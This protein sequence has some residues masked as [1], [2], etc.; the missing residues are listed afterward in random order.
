MSQPHDH[1]R[2]RSMSRLLSEIGFRNVTF[3]AT[4]KWTDMDVEQ[5]I[6][7]GIL[8]TSLFPRMEERNDT[9]RE[10]YIKYAANAVSQIRRIRAAA[11]ANEPVIIMEDDLMA[12]GDIEVVRHNLCHAL[13]DIPATADMVYLEYCFE[14]CEKLRYNPRYPTLAK[15]TRP[16][17]AA[18]IFFTM[19]GARRVAALCWPVFDVIDRMYPALIRA[20]ALEAYLLTPQAFYQD[21]IFA[22]NMHRT[23]GFSSGRAHRRHHQPLSAGPTCTEVE[24]GVAHSETIL[25]L[26]RTDVRQVG[27]ALPHA[28]LVSML[29]ALEETDV[30]TIHERCE[31]GGLDVWDASEDAKTRHVWLKFAMPDAWTEKT[32]LAPGCRV[33]Y[34]EWRDPE[35]SDDEPPELGSWTTDS[36]CG[37]LLRFGPESNCLGS[38]HVCDLD[39]Y[40]VTPDGRTLLD[41]TRVGIHIVS[42]QAKMPTDLF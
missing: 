29:A 39:I 25:A 3:P 16:A 9:N 12:G 7:D 30:S 2:R 32:W 14:I 36:Q 23:Q 13:A 10:G 4:T 11:A 34:E 15:A 6:A 40:L 35:R 18:A 31:Y 1:E 17:C 38:D 41:V 8:S 5:M 37:A 24:A 28:G 20:G 27:L 26:I 22:S 33:I 19:K 21:Q 42:A